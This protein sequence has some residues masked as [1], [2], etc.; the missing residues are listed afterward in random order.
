MLPRYE[1]TKTKIPCENKLKTAVLTEVIA[2][3]KHDSQI[4]E[5]DVTDGIK[6]YYTTGWVLMRPSGTEPL[7]R[8]YSEAKTT[9]DATDLAHRFIALVNQAIEKNKQS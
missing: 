9:T 1:V 6:A 5:T 8:V 4:K 2:Q 7:F 3:V